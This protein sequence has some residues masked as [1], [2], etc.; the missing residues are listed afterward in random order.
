MSN[1]IFRFPA[2]VP[3][4]TCESL[5]A[6]ILAR[7]SGAILL[8]RAIGTTVTVLQGEG[9]VWLK[10]YDTII[11]AIFPGQ[12]SFSPHDDPHLAT[13]AWIGKIV[14]DNGI[15]GTVWRE[16][17]HASDGEGPCVPR[18]HAGLLAIDGDR[19]RPVFGRTYPVASHA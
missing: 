10:L 4:L 15:G 18:G 1:Y 6:Y 7:P 5:N 12:V 11:A 8:S 13:T 19:S 14:R 17:R 9:F 16:R 3:K 2:D